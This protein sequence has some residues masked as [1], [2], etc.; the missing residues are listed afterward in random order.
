M[1]ITILTGKK[2]NTVTKLK[3]FDSVVIFC[4]SNTYTDFD[5]YLTFI[6]NIIYIDVITCIILL[7]YCMLRPILY[8]II[9]NI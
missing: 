8:Y 7:H 3:Q 2:N 4:I 5:K 1:F 6:F 9:V